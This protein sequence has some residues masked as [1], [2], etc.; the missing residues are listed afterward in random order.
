MPRDKAVS[1]MSLKRMASLLAVFTALVAAHFSEGTGPPW[2]SNQVI[3]TNLREADG[4]EMRWFWLDRLHVR[5]IWTTENDGS[6]H[7]YSW[8]LAADIE[9]VLKDVDAEQPR[10]LTVET[11]LK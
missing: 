10:Q 6:T 4:E 2:L 3:L 8:E 7:S 5:I 9:A 1:R 11:L